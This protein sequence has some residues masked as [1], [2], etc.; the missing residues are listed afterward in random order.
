MSNVGNRPTWGKGTRMTR[1]KNKWVAAVV[2]FVIAFI[3]AV[4]ISV[5]ASIVGF[6]LIFP[7]KAAVARVQ[8][9]TAP[10][11]NLILGA[12]LMVIAIV[13]YALGIYGSIYPGS[14][15][16]APFNFMGPLTASWIAIGIGVVFYLRTKSPE[17]VGKLGQ[18]LGEEGGS[19]AEAGLA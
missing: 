11:V 5:W 10:W 13:A 4:Y 9:E 14:A 19:E 1:T 17:L 8:I 15:P 3:V 16:S 12:A 7:R 6:A 18:A 2:V